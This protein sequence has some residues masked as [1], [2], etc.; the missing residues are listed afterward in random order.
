MSPC[1]KPQPAL[2]AAAI[3]WTALKGP[4][5]AGYYPPSAFGSALLNLRSHVSIR[6]SVAVLAE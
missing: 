2:V 1:I 5:V 4:G 6:N 3:R